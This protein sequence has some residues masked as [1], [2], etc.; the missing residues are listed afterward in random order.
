MQ[1]V[2]EI[3]LLPHMTSLIVPFRLLFA[4]LADV[5]LHILKSVHNDRQV[6][7]RVDR[8]LDVVGAGSR[9]RTD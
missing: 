2:S 6:H 1:D 7:V 3:G 5:Q 8:A 4:R 9:E